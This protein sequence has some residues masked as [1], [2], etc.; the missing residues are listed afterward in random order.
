MTRRTFTV[1]DPAL[2]LRVERSVFLYQL[3]IGSTTLALLITASLIHPQIFGNELLIAGVLIIFV[4]TGVAAAVPWRYLD[5]K[6]IAILPIHDLLG[7]VIAREGEPLFGF[8]FLLVFPVIWLAAHF[9]VRGAAGSVILATIMV[10]GVALVRPAPIPSDE[11]PR[12]VAIT[13][14]LTGL[15][16]TIYTTTQRAASQRALLTQQSALFE[17]VLHR[18][19]RDER[20]LDQ[21]FNTV[22][23]GLVGFDRDGNPNFINAAQRERLDRFVP[24]GGDVSKVVV[25][26][27]DRVTPIPEYNRPVQRAKRGET[28]NRL[29]IW[30]GTPGQQDRVAVLISSRPIFDENDEYDGGVM[31][32]RDITSELTAVKARDDLAA[33]ITHELRTP[34]NSIMG[35]LELALDDERLAKETRRKLDVARRNSER[36]LT[37]VDDLLTAASDTTQEELTYTPGR[38]D[39]AAVA[40]EAIESLIPLAAERDISVAWG[41]WPVMELTADAFRLRQVVDNLVSNAIKYNVPSGQITIT[42][43][44]AAQSHENP[45]LTNQ[46]IFD[47]GVIELRVTDTGLGLSETEQRGLFDRFYRSDSARASTVHGTGLGLSLS[48]DIMRQ[49]GG[50]LR[51]ESILGTGTT[52]IATF[53]IRAEN[54]SGITTVRG[55]R[56]EGF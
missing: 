28:I 27:V 13:I 21:I 10:W 29:T 9:G 34:L 43:S 5:K 45:G 55:R 35:Y 14:M 33:S 46:R 56:T 36:L 39:L 41:P 8:T 52:A 1:R 17:G 16:I 22:D 30:L 50:D 40:S 54:D 19:R 23:F 6:W 24:P 25:Y 37:L 11:L 20:T 4:T 32:S 49:H 15:A 18:S 53:P 38:C 3:L 7:F 47:R 48:R 26:D 51:L 2:R 42:L 31:F 12:L 44:T